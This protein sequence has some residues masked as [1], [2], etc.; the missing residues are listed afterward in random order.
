MPKNLH[1]KKNTTILR[2]KTN[3]EKAENTEKFKFDFEFLKVE[4]DIIVM[5]IL[6]LTVERS[7]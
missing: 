1:T 7:K 2:E 6:N 3:N 5:L 4:H